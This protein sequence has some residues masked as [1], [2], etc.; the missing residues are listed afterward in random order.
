MYPA[1]SPPITVS[2]FISHSWAYSEHYDKLAE[3]FFSESWN[4]DGRPI[5]FVDRSVPKDNPIHYAPNDASLY[6]AISAR[7]AQSNVVVI[8]MGLYATHSKW[9]GKEIQACKE[10][11]RPI[12]AVNPWGQER[13]SSVVA[14][15]AADVVGWN[16][17][18]IV[19]AVW[20]LYRQ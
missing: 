13:K 11:G 3:W 1:S 14:A 6:A 12:V 10:L 19:G 17:Q 4:S 2:V 8:P 20:G 5:Q 16:K 18:S 7:I 15:A 9:I